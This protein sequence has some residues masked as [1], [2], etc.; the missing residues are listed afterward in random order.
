MCR[1]VK[2]QVFSCKLFSFDWSKRLEK[3]ISLQNAGMAQICCAFTELVLNETNCATI[4]QRK[5]N[6][7]SVSNN[8]SREEVDGDMCYVFHYYPYEIAPF[9]F[10]MIDIKIPISQLL[11]YLR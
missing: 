3:E 6:D 7:F 8:I 2:N 4:S 1:N 5:K 11:P 9:S 10:G